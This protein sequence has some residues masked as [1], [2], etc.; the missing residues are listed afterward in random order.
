MAKIQKLDNSESIVLF[1]KI[2]DC[3]KKQDKGFFVFRKLKTVHGWCEWDSIV[4][5]Y[6]KELIPTIIHECIHLI[7]PEWSESQVS[8]SEK[9]VVNTITEDDAVQLLLFFIKKL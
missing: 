1:N 6:R 7:E 8:Y 4:I 5:D 9:R 2:L 3:I